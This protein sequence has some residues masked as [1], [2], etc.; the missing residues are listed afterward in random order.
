MFENTTRT[1]EI[2]RKLLP[3]FMKY[4]EIRDKLTHNKPI[5]EEE[6]REEARKLTQVIMELGPTFIKLGQ[7][8]SVRPD[9]F[10]Q[11]YLDELSKLQDEVTP[12]PFDQIKDILYRDLADLGI[13]KIEEKPIAS[14]SLGQVHLV[15]SKDGNIYAVK[16]K[17]PNIE[18]IVETDIRIIKRFLPL[19]R[20]LFDSSILESLRVTIDEF[21]KTLQKEMDYKREASFL[22]KFREQ[23]SSDFSRVK[24]PRLIKATNN[25]IVM[26]YIG[27]HKVTSEE[28]K[29]IIPP[30][31]LAYRVF[32]LFM[33]ML[34]EKEYFHAD[35]HPGNLSIDEKG[36]IILYDYGMI[37]SLPDEIKKK[38]LLVYISVTRRDTYT[39][40]NIL[41][42]LGA[43]Q[44]EVDREVLALGIDLFLKEMSGIE[45]SEYEL[46]DYLKL[47]NQVFYRFPLRLPS[48]LWLP[49]R[50]LN[51][52]EGTCREID[53]DFDFMKNLAEFLQN[54][55]LLQ[56]A[57]IEQVRNTFNQILTKFRASLLTN[58]SIYT[59]LNQ[60]N[61]KG[62]NNVKIV[63]L[64]VIALSIIL[65]IM[66]KDATLSLL[67]ALFGLSF[68]IIQS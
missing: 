64:G 61:K 54:E 52:L 25:I 50:M 16:V 6:I 29:K 51:V 41:D 36:N 26:E 28:V 32:Q 40:V 19:L 56:Q 35:P 11:E 3:R 43:I 13:V 65:Y 5:S 31:Q 18:K 60:Y 67:I 20:I 49:L 38:L 27:G 12:A 59:R 24:V 23:L 8:L 45:V 62:I 58:S 55:G 53:P 9:L 4:R 66:E 63:S 22:V 30:S 46:S 42:D 33:T 2:A 7:V 21:Y 48:G 17:R 1:I 47:A 15:Y 39:F 37:G 57:F 44:P 34:L 14:A 10:P 68:S